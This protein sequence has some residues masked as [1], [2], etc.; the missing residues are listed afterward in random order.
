M[1]NSIDPNLL[2]KPENSF[3]TIYDFVKLVNSSFI[4]D[5]IHIYY[6]L[7]ITFFLRNGS[8][9]NRDQTRSRYN[10]ICDQKNKHGKINI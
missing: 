6:L 2:K 10:R 8:Y 5:I 1:G 4:E 9:S 3:Q 7:S